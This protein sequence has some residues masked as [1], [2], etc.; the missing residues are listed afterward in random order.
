[1][2]PEAGKPPP[3][4]VFEQV[5]L[6]AAED[7]LDLRIDER[8]FPHVIEVPAPPSVFDSRRRTSLS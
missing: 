6:T 2:Y 7:R 5:A 1:M 3:A 4:L 8:Q